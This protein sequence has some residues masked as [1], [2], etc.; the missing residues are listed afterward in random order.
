MHGVLMNY[1]RT[2]V[3]AKGHQVF[4]RLVPEGRGF[5]WDVEDSKNRLIRRDSVEYET[6][7]AAERAASE[8]V[9]VNLEDL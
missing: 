4:V 3:G 8:W 6:P 2:K 5:M 1:R 7:G 9:L